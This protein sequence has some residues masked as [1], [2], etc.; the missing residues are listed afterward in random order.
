MPATSPSPTAQITELNED[1]ESAK[2][3]Q[4][5]LDSELDLI[6][7]QQG[8]LEEILTGLEKKA[9][10]QQPLATTLHAD[11]QRTKMSGRRGGGGK[12]EGCLKL[13]MYNVRFHNTM[14]FLQFFP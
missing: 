10:L 12:R 11:V 1:V 8:E 7:S 2:T 14:E 3:Q 6:G 4:K 13:D 5:R 9:D